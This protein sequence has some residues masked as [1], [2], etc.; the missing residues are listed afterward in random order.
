MD[1]ENKDKKIDGEIYKTLE[2][3]FPE[4]FDLS[5]EELE[6][7]IDVEKKQREAALGLIGKDDSEETAQAE[8]EESPVETPVETPEEE[9]AADTVEIARETEVREEETVEEAEE[10]VSETA[11]E[12][13]TVPDAESVE[14]NPLIGDMD[15]L[16]ALFIEMNSDDEVIERIGSFDEEQ[17]TEEETKGHKTVNWFFDF[18]EI[19][20]VCLTAIIVIFAFFVRL[21]RVDGGSMNDTLVDGEYLLV[22]DFC[23]TPTVGDIV[24]LQDTAIQNDALTKPLVKR[25][26][27][28]AG[29]T[30]D[31]SPDG[32]VT[33][34]EPDGTSY[35]LD[36]SFT[37]KE[38]YRYSASAS[39]FEVPE[40]CVFV[41]GDNRN[42]STDSRYQVGYVDERCI[43]GKALCR[44][45]PFN[46][47]T[48]FKNPYNN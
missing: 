48:F 10:T 4:R 20:A 32:S 27:A 7:Q 45:F 33:I 36:Q 18:L 46:S 47:F 30:V 35:E 31:I 25:L 37:K 8:A 14:N 39:H 12:E 16:D 2:G 44:V 13:I 26:I 42:G 1:N 38:P 15:P 6:E 29:Q 21:T 43:F 24:V 34:T 41:M 3:Y 9:P 40:G 19:F 5:P 17:Q 28:T 23:Y 22:T 11:E